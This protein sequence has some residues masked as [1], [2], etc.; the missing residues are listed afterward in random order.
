MQ[1]FTTWT[2]E[3]FLAF[4]ARRNEVFQ[5]TPEELEAQ[6]AEYETARASAISEKI[7][8]YGIVR[9]ETVTKE[10]VLQFLTAIDAQQFVGSDLEGWV[11]NQTVLFGNLDTAFDELVLRYL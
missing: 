8:K 6:R 4:D 2:R 7:S 11:D 5:P 1:D 10:F 9:P 3:D